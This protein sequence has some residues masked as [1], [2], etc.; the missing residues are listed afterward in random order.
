MR[1]IEVPS[2]L[3]INDL[4]P[5][6]RPDPPP[7]GVGQVL[8]RMSAVSL[9]F[10]DLLV[11]QGRDR[12]RPPTGRIP[13]SDG[14]GV[15]QSIG[16]GTDRVRAGQRVI[17]TFLPKWISGPL[18]AENREGAL[19][20]PS[21]DGV[22]AEQVVLD[23]SAVVPAPDYLTDTEAATL[24]AAALTAWHALTRANS[25]GS[26]ST[27]LV[28][29]TGGVSLFALQIAVA[30]GAKVIATS[31]S[32]IKLNRLREFGA[33]ETV[34]YVKHRDWG[35]EVIELTDGRGVDHAID[36]GGA[37]TLG[38]SILSASIGGVVSIVGLVGGIVAQINLGEVF[39]KNL[40]L[41]GIETGSRSMLEEMVHWFNSKRLHPIIDKVFP[42]EDSRAALLHLQAGGHMGKVC[43]AF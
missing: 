35:R 16:P 30:A 42:F 19:G 32:D 28:E 22:L 10:R 2:S 1:L 21:A 40:R 5:V 14:V 8:I 29:G 17:T 20:G 41:D 38:Q 13:V 6:E 36:I 39:Q 9:N 11:T 25:L 34:N 15:V 26:G 7:P 43:I 23:A 37:T 33:S 31:S 18:T 4:R 3:N 24:P 12:W 27:V